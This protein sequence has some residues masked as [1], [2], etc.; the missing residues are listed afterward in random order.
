MIEGSYVYCILEGKVNHNF[1]KIGVLNRDVY[2]VSHNGISAIVSSIPFK[3]IQPNVDNI[4]AH[5]RVVEA[6]RNVGTALPVRFGVIF[7]TEEV[8]RKLLTRKMSEYKTKLRKFRD[9]DEFGVKIILDKAGLKRIQ[10]SVQE[11]SETVKKMKGE[12][13]CATDGA[14]YFLKMKMDEKIKYETFK[15]IEQLVSEIHLQLAKFAEDKC[16]LKPE[17]QDLILNAAY[18]INRKDYH[19]FNVMFEKLK[20][21]YESRGLIFHMSGPWAPYSFC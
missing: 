1:G 12:I 15:T 6:S 19:T 10:R 3:E 18:L 11:D 7:K 17:Y 9:K 20:Q 5:Q 21:K 14:A 16:L 8:I 2:A 13:S 4:A